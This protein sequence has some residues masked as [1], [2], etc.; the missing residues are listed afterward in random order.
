MRRMTLNISAV[1]RR[2]AG[3]ARLA[4][5]LGVAAGAAACGG[6]PLRRPAAP[7]PAG[8]RIV[9]L[10]ELLVLQASGAPPRDTSVTFVQG[11]RRV[12]LLQHA[13]PDDVP[14]G[15]LE[16]PSRA[17]P[18]S[19]AP[20]T[21]T[22]RPEPGAYALSVTSDVPWR[23]GLG[24]PTVRF[25]WPVHFVAPPAAR[26][27]YADAAAYARALVV[28]HPRADGAVVLLPSMRPA[29]DNLQAPMPEPGRYLVA[30]PR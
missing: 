7:A 25:S 12:I 27:R 22:V 4:G 1:V 14:F 18:D 2:L 19:G 30:A 9:P 6:G 11:Q 29:L 3:V 21:V 23:A 20:V 5:L 13:S 8:P 17:F 28:G 16:F 24:T 26:E 10:A 15:E